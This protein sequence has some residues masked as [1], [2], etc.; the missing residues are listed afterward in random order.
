MRKIL[1]H[2]RALGRFPKREPGRLYRPGHCNPPRGEL[3]TRLWTL[4]PPRAPDP[5]DTWDPSRMGTRALPRY[6]ART[7]Y[8]EVPRLEVDL[9]RWDDD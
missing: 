7:D 1:D 9:V 2:P 3:L 5:N 6:L 4:P 8:S